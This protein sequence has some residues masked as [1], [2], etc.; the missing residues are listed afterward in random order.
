MGGFM[1]IPDSSSPD[2]RT[3]GGRASHFNNPCCRNFSTVQV[4]VDCGSASD[5][6]G[7]SDIDSSVW[8][9]WRR[10]GGSDGW[11]GGIGVTI[12]TGCAQVVGS[13]RSV[14][15]LSCLFGFGFVGLHDLLVQLLPLVSKLAWRPCNP[16]MESIPCRVWLSDSATGFP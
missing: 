15:S 2:W 12:K 14:S 6:V 1:D 11:R 13:S 7:M 8:M 5:D 10:H 4:R 9:P 16:A 3:P